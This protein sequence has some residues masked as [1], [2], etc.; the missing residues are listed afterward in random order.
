M[1]RQALIVED[2]LA[3]GCLL[4]ECVRSWGFEPTVF[5]QGK[6]ALP[7]AR[8]HQP[9]LLLPLRRGGGRASE[10]LL[11]LPRHREH[12]RQLRP[13]RP[14][15]HR[16]GGPYHAALPLPD[17]RADLRPPPRQ[18][19]CGRRAADPHRSR[20]GAPGGQAQ[21]LRG[22]QLMAAVDRASSWRVLDGGAAVQVQLPRARSDVAELINLVRGLPS[23]T[24]V[25][26]WDAT[27]WARRR[28][29]R[30]AAVA[31]L[32]I[33]IEYIAVPSVGSPLYLVQDA[34]ETLRFFWSEVAALPFRSRLRL[35]GEIA[36]RLVRALSLWRWTSLVLPQRV[37]V[38][39]RQ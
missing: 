27:R 32:S 2:E 9:D 13:A 11:R 14:L 18:P 10:P 24:S 1:I 33:A 5:E 30:F 20:P 38:G 39:R 4:A 3:T 6:P 36:L 21:T 23:G 26:V 15:R 7:W 34:P 22:A 29:R 8:R 16:S 35:P 19:R 17:A 37:V 28:C 25:A 31:E 12:H